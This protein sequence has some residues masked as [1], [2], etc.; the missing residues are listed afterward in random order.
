M[1]N[2][3]WLKSFPGCLNSGVEGLLKWVRMKVVCEDM[4]YFV[5]RGYT[6]KGLGCMTGSP[7]KNMALNTRD[8]EV[9]EKWSKLIN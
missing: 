6:I 4:I 8:L 2:R 7:L 1:V 9:L 3:G 5:L